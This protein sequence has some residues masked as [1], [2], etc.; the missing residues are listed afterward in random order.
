ML[1]GKQLETPS[2]LHSA[3]LQRRERPTYTC[4]P[5]RGEARGVLAVVD[6]DQLRGGDVLTAWLPAP[7][8]LAC[9]G[10][11]FRGNSWRCGV[12]PTPHSWLQVEEATSAGLLV[13]REGGKE[14]GRRGGHTDS[15]G[16]RASPSETWTARP[17]S[18]RFP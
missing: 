13:Q 6:D 18:E 5:A 17:P 3:N 9:A 7:D 10:G 4:I 16:A 15:A 12:C 2:Q 11:I 8:G 1:R 14:R